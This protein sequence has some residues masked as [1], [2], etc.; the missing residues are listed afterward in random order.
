MKTGLLIKNGRFLVK[1]HINCNAKINCLPI[2]K[3][4]ED[5][6]V[7]AI[8]T[9]TNQLIPLIAPEENIVN[10]NLDVIKKEFLNSLIKLVI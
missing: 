1:L 4:V 9:Q 8:I 2:L 3:V 10:D 7:V 5:E 6:L